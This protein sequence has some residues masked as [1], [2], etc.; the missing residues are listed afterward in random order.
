M[1]ATR[2][3]STTNCASVNAVRCSF[4]LVGS[5]PGWRVQGDTAV[6]P[7]P[8]ALHPRLTRWRCLCAV[9]W[10]C[11]RS[12]WWWWKNASVRLVV[13]RGIS[14]LWPPCTCNW[15]YCS[16]RA[17]FSR[18]KSSVRIRKRTLRNYNEVYS[19]FCT[20]QRNILALRKYRPKYLFPPS[21]H[22]L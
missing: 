11:G 6:R 15:R 16:L 2:W 4:P 1:A 7:V 9:G 17:T 13:R 14:R 12:A 5:L 10:R 20:L 3:Q 19:I 18:C 21:Q 22:L 8:A